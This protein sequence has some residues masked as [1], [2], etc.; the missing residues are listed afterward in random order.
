MHPERD[1][2]SVRFVGSLSMGIGMVLLIL[3]LVG[4]LFALFSGG[5]TDPA[6]F[7]RGIYIFIVALVMASTML[8][9]GAQLQSARYYGWSDIEN[10][11]MI[12]T[13]EVIVMA[14][15]SLASLWLVPPLAW[16]GGFILFALFTV[17]GAIIRLT[18]RF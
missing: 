7:T 8:G 3:T 16:L 10:I 5:S 9:C 11:R 17:R 15:G 14:L 1:I 2:R 18:R 6:A 12:W 4:A 13:S